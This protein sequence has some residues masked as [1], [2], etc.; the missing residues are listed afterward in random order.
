MYSENTKLLEIN[1]I[2]DVDGNVYRSIKK[3]L[4]SVINTEGFSELSAQHIRD[5]VIITELNE[6][7]DG[8]N[9]MVIAANLYGKLR[10]GVPQIKK[11]A[12]SSRKLGS[13]FIDILAEDYI[14]PNKSLLQNIPDKQ[15]FTVAEYEYIQESILRNSFSMV[16]QQR[17][18]EIDD[19]DV[20][21]ILTTTPIRS[22]FHDHI[23][24]KLGVNNAKTLIVGVP[25]ACASGALAFNYLTSGRLDWYINNVL[26]QKQKETLTHQ[27]ANVVIVSSDDIFGIPGYTC[28]HTTLQ[29]FSSGTTASALTYSTNPT[30]GANL[31]S[32]LLKARTF[33]KFS[34][35]ILYPLTLDEMHQMPYLIWNEDVD[36]EM[37][38]AEKFNNSVMLLPRPGVMPDTSESNK[39][40]V[41]S[42][43][44]GAFGKP[45]S[46]IFID[47]FTEHKRLYPDKTTHLSIHQPSEAM[48]NF[49]QRMLQRAELDKV[50]QIDERT[51]MGGNTCGS[52]IIQSLGRIGSKIKSGD[53]VISL[54][55]GG[56]GWTTGTVFQVN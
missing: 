12:I 19:I 52:T 26:L 8:E 41:T 7:A 13:P 36:V 1:P 50:V 9:P 32:S 51:T 34:S 38:N 39:I 31:G 48:I 53:H 35:A 16:L 4:E 42:K 56:M 20:M 14:N 30:V 17:G 54:G 3:P 29:L 43:T 46:E 11:A 5:S 45:A 37:R 22:N 21:L 33:E 49:I 25:F 27:E 44:V 10:E 2:E 28:N 47:I 24:S 15:D 40:V 18:W 6:V 55:M 23:S